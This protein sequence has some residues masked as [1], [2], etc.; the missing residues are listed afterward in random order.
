MGAA[1]KAVV[2]LGGNLGNRERSL[3]R[4]VR[5][6]SLLPGTDVLRLSH[7][8]ETDPF[9]V[10]SPQP[11]YLNACAELATELPPRAL[12]G[13]CLGIEGAF[14]RVRR[15]YHGAR[16]IDLDLL[17]VEGV[18]MDSA[19]CTLP[20]PRMLERA[21]VLVPLHDLYPEGDALGVDFAAAYQR[22]DR[23][24]VRFSRPFSLV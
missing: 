19:E 23:S 3:L 5:A 8:Y 9:D 22:V 7:L 6:L 18:T 13:A 20:H 24:G 2:G 12:L 15:E 14:G 17:L 4:A 10:R 11:D 21:F 1:R 16:R